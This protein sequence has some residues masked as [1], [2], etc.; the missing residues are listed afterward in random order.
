MT[1]DVLL[2]QDVMQDID[3]ENIEYDLN[4]RKD[5][6]FFYFENNKLAKVDKGERATDYRI[7][8]DN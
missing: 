6:R 2:K 3:I 4:W 1:T 8:I 5:H 7:R